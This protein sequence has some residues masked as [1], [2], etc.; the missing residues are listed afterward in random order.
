[1]I[2]D[3]VPLS[4]SPVADSPTY[5]GAVSQ[6]SETWNGDLFL[7]Y[8]QSDIGHTAPDGRVAMRRS[9]DQGQTWTD[10]GTVHNEPKR[11]TIDPSVVYDPE[12]GRVSLFDVAIG[13][14]ES[15]ESPSDLESKPAR[16]KCDTYLVASRNHGV[17]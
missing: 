13:F 1:M 7:F 14:S 10:P 11:D 15:V 9:T 17:S 12:T 5:D 3:Q 6:I 8:H 4:P 16:E 2:G